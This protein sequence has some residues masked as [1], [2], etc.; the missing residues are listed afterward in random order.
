M[1]WLVAYNENLFD[2]LEGEALAVRLARLLERAAT[3]GLSLSEGR[4]AWR[5]AVIEW[6]DHEPTA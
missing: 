5:A 2:G 6:V 3:S 1:A 4:E